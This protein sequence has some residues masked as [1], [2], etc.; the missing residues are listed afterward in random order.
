MKKIGIRKSGGRNNQG[1]I[2][3]RSIGGGFKRLYRELEF[4]DGNY[5]QERNGK[6]TAIEFD[7][8][9]S[10]YIAACQGFGKTF[11]K[12]VGGLSMPK[13]GDTLNVVNLGSVS[14]GSPVYNVSL[15]AGKGGQLA[16]ARGASC[17][18]VKQEIET[19]TTVVRLPSSAIKRLSSKNTCSVGTVFGEAITRL[20][21][22]GAHRRL[23]VRPKVRGV[24]MN[25]IDHPNGGKSHTNKI[26]NL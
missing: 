5:I 11:Y 12:I 7:P 15:R 26:K 22:A 2:T 14:I 6:I 10:A 19:G 21:T 3:V 1:R 8:N 4:R 24:A 18:V 20:G 13:I 17:T 9:R 25:P 16:K 23:G